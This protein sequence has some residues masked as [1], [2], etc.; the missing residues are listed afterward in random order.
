MS[1]A[2]V[3][4]PAKQS[5]FK[6]TMS[7]TTGS[8][9]AAATLATGVAM[10]G[11][12]AGSVHAELEETQVAFTMLEEEHVA[13]TEKHASLTDKLDETTDLI[14]KANDSIGALQAEVTALTQTISNKDTEIQ[15]LNESLTAKDAEIVT[16]QAS[17]SQTQSNQ[18]SARG[19]SSQ[20][21]TQTAPPAQ[22]YYKNCTEARKAGAAPVYRGDP[23][24][25]KHL[26]RDN[27]GIGCE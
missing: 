23:G 11:A 13:L 19:F 12:S 2:P 18:N 26:D 21:N 24:Y 9:I 25:G 17:R 7:R 5:F 27:D 8:I 6:K 14:A 22:V 15:T 1:A 16:L 10:G 4:A 3:P 20:S